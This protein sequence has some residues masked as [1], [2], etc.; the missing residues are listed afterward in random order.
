MSNYIYEW[1]RLVLEHEHEEVGRSALG[2]RLLA[3]NIQFVGRDERD[4]I[5]FGLSS[6]LNWAFQV[7]Q[8]LGKPLEAPYVFQR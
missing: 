4:S 2:W 3:N 8:S 6:L 1:S 7:L 5:V